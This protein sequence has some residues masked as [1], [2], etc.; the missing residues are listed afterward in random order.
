MAYSQPVNCEDKFVPGLMEKSCCAGPG[1][2]VTCLKQEGPGGKFMKQ[3]NVLR[4]VLAGLVSGFIIYAFEGVTNGVI[5]SHGWKLWAALA[6]RV[7]V[8]P[9]ANYSLI[10]WG[11]QALIAGLIGA[12]VYA[13]IR[14]W[15]GINLRAAY[16]S[17]VIIWGVGWLGMSMDKLALG[18]EPTG[19]VHDNL[20]AALLGCL[21]GQIAVSF[22][23]K[24][25][26]Q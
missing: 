3:L 10:M 2:G 13:A 5:L 16:I 25:M 11:I 19:F 24:D 4:M 17:A 9:D 23:Y 22:I 1:N 15:V 14:V 8:L 20:L 7:F 21:V 26:A 12:F 6:N 18:V